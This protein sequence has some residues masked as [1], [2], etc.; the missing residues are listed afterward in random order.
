MSA[1]LTIFALMAIF[2]Y[3]Y[4]DHT[5]KRDKGKNEGAPIISYPTISIDVDN[6]S[7]NY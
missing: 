1:V 7:L 3:D 6:D 5:G 2:Y 4:A